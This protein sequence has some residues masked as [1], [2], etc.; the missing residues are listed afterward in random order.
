MHWIG[1]L[2]GAL[3]RRGGS[4][5]WENKVLLVL[6]SVGTKIEAVCVH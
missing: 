6:M 1:D 3:G 2:I 4:G 5:V